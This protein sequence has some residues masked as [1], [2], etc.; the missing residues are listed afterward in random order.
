[1]EIEIRGPIQNK[2]KYHLLIKKLVSHSLMK[3]L[4][5][6][7]QV[8]IFLEKDD[9]DFRIKS[10]SDKDYFEF[11]H[12]SKIGTQRT[13]RD[14]TTMK[15]AKTEISNLLNILE[16]LGFKEGYVSFVER[17]DLDTEDILWSFKFG[18]VIGDYWEAEAKDGLEERLEVLGKEIV[19]FL[20]QE[21]E[22]LKLDIWDEEEFRRIRHQKWKK[23]LPKPIKELAGVLLDQNEKNTLNK[24]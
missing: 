23:V 24:Q 7:F 22:K 18:S 4:S 12:K 11:V 8:V 6:L 1:M 16:N 9:Q 5:R 20:N 21:A 3:N 15:L 17:I 19:A 2:R 14:E 10:D 13:I